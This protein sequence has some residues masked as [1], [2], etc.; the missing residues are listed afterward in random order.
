MIGMQKINKKNS[1]HNKLWHWYNV[2]SWVQ[3]KAIWESNNYVYRGNQGARYLAAGRYNYN[4]GA[5]RPALEVL[6][7]DPL[8]SNKKSGDIVKFGTL[9]INNKKNKKAH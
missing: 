2:F 3:D 4:G 8:I 5:W 9:Y 7:S 1:I 6:D